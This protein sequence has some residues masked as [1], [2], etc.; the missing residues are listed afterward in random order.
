MEAATAFARMLLGVRGGE[1]LREEILR[2]GSRWVSARKLGGWLEEDDLTVVGRRL[3][4]ACYILDAFAASLYFAWKYADDFAGAV[5]ANAMAGGDNCHRGAVVG[6]LCGGAAGVDVGQPMK[7]RPL[8]RA[9]GVEHF[10]EAPGGQCRC[11][12]AFA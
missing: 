11:G 3:S 1:G 8:S 2:H 4:P 9:A 12:G 6:S 5:T 7:R 10:V